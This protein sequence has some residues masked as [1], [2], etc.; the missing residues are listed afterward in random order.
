M[1][2]STVQT[3]S[4]AQQIDRHMRRA[5]HT[6]QFVLVLDM[7]LL[8]DQRVPQ[9]KRAVEHLRAGGEDEG[10]GG[11]VGGLGCVQARN[12]AW[13]VALALAGREV[14]GVLGDVESCHDSAGG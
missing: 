3:F 8:A 9:A 11:H 10:N 14:D 13:L 2:G 6:L 4:S 5:S 12:G 1:A 7:Q